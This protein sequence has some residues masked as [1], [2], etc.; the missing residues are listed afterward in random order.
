MT[1][2]ELWQE[3]VRGDQPSWDSLFKMFG[4]RI[5]QFFLKNTGDYELAG[6]STQEV[7]IK[8][9]QHREKFTHGSLTTWIFRVAR[10][11]LIDLWRRKGKREI[12]TDQLPEPIDQ[13]QGV[14]E[15][16]LAG[17]ERMRL[18]SLLDE[19]LDALSD[20][21]RILL[22]LVYLGGLSF[23]E[24]ASVMEIP[25]GTAKTQVRQARLRLARILVETLEFSKNTGGTR[26][27]LQGSSGA[28]ADNT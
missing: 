24:L 28:P 27:E 17:L 18:V 1:P 25:L 8:L 26:H 5:F 22:C 2:E 14:E 12:P 16:V 10:N 15:Q 20:Q 6:D 7:F 19:G 4:P 11:L 3:A 21:D 23:S 9:F 13:E